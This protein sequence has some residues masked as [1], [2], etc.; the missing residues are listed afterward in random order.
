MYIV[1]SGR[2][3]RGG[4]GPYNCDAIDQ[5]Q[6]EDA[7]AN[8]DQG[9]HVDGIRGSKTTLKTSEDGNYTRNE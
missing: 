6:T 4:E 7:E 1:S 5:V 3:R 2:S 9:L 8:E